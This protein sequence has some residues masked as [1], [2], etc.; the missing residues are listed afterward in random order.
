MK[1]IIRDPFLFVNQCLRNSFTDLI[2]VLPVWLNIT[3]CINEASLDQDRWFVRLIQ[4]VQITPFLRPAIDKSTSRANGTGHLRREF[5]MAN[6]QH[7]GASSTLR[8]H[9]G[10]EVY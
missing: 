3:I 5:S 6:V 7:L 2:E 10:I 9:V 1:P 4:E 8:W